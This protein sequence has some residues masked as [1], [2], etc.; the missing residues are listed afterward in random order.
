MTDK[1]Y[2]K[3]IKRLQKVTKKWLEAMGIGWFQVDME[4]LRVVDSDSS[5]NAAVVNTQW[6][7]RNAHIT[8]YLPVIAEVSDDKL[9]NIVVHEFTHILI[10]PLTLVDKSEDLDIQHEYATECI[11]RAFIWVREAGQRDSVPKQTHKKVIK[12]KEK[13]S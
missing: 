9:N 11:A 2:E 1:E 4:Y 10:N 13:K 12:L 8:W 6:Q 5:S 3:Q 7:Y